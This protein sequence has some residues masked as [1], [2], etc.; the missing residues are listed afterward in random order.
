MLKKQ[1]VL[2]KIAL[3]TMLLSGSKPLA[4]LVL[5]QQNQELAPTSDQE[6]IERIRGQMKELSSNGS[7]ETKRVLQHSKHALLHYE[8]RSAVG[9]RKGAERSLQIAHAAIVWGSRLAAL[10][11]SEKS[12][13]RTQE[14]LIIASEKAKASKAALLVAMRQYKE[15]TA[16]SAESAD[17]ATEQRE[18]RIEK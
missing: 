8:R 2:I 10:Q 16:R 6:M 18:G 7:S 12:Y 14:R 1:L 5:A 13:K 3:L 17:L 11:T 9:D 4:S 15:F